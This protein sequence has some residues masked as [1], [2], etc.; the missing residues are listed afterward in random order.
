M[1]ISVS[2]TQLTQNS[3]EGNQVYADDTILHNKKR[4][5][6]MCNFLHFLI[7]PSKSLH[8]WLKLHHF[9]CSVITLSINML[10]TA[11]KINRVPP[12]VLKDGPSEN[13]QHSR[14]LNQRQIW[15][16][17][18]KDPTKGSCL[19]TTWVRRDNLSAASKCRKGHALKTHPPARKSKAAT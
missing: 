3:K 10:I 12:N 5:V 2:G 9:S 16:I 18:L 19:T 7:N 4:T 17:Y 13:L 15:L 8:R 6:S 1:C 14:T 11:D